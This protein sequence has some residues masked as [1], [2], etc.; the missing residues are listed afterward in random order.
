MTCH[1]Q[2]WSRRGSTKV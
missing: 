1:T 2:M